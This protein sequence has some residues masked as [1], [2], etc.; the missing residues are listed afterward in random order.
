M[1]APRSVA[2]SY[3]LAGL[4]VDPSVFDAQ[5]AHLRAGG[6]RSITVDRLSRYVAAKKRPPGKTFVITIDDGHDDGFIYALPILR[7]YGFV[8]TFYVVV[9]RIGRPH[10]LTWA[11]ILSLKAAGMEI[12]NHTMDHLNLTQLSAAQVAYEIDQAQ[13]VLAERLGAAP[14]TFAYPYWA[15]DDAV[16]RAVRAAGLGMAMTLGSVP[17]E[18]QSDRYFVPRFDLYSSLSATELLAKIAPYA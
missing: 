15:Y 17:Y 7:K 8:A 6:W 5:L 1:I 14:T 4:D 3:S 12:G 13:R 9:G 16:V 18:A 11:E 10:T 2:S